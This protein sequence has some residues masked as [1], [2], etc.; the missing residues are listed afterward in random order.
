MDASSN[1]RSC[2]YRTGYDFAVPLRHQWGF[3][4]FTDLAPWHRDYFLTVK[5]RFSRVRPEG[6]RRGVMQYERLVELLN[7]TRVGQ[8]TLGTRDDREGGWL[9]GALQQY[10]CFAAFSG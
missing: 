5:V 8:R 9:V 1:M 2:F 6:F 4:N 3:G 7:A 10:S